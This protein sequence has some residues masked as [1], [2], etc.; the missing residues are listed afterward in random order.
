MNK[1]RAIDPAQILTH[2]LLNANI[3]KEIERKKHHNS[4]P[5][6][7]NVSIAQEP[8]KH[9]DILIEQE[10]EKPRQS[11]YVAEFSLGKRC[12]WIVFGILTC[13]FGFWFYQKGNDDFIDGFIDGFVGH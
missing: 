11:E 12:A 8:T 7:D 9:K 10:L 13:G 5:K 3:Q 2:T 4:K 6:I 1:N